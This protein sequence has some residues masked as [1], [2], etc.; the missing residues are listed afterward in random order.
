MGIRNAYK[1]LV[2][3]PEGS[4]P[5]GRPRRRWEDDIRTN[6]EVVVRMWTGYILLRIGT[7]GGLL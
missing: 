3:K 4:R 1:I 7:S 6:F 5:L 2:I